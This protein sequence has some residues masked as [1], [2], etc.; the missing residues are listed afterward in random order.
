VAATVIATLPASPDEFDVPS[1][2]K[3]HVAVSDADWLAA[4]LSQADMI[5]D[6]I[7]AVRAEAERRLLAGDTVP[8]F[9]IVEGR[10]GNRAWNDKAKAEATLKAMRL[11]IEQMY[12]LSLIS[13][14]TAEK[15]LKAGTIGPRQW[16]SLQDMVTRADG[17]K[18]V[19]PNS[20]PRPALSVTAV[21]EDFSTV[22]TD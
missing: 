22:V 19:A 17:K 21:E 16:K 18:H 7:K 15:L 12:D 3:E 1:D 10:A 2:A 20:D 5:E 4:A 9:K 13:P 8:G 6:W 14:T 11:T